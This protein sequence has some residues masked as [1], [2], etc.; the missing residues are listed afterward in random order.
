MGGDQSLDEEEEEEDE[1][2]LIAAKK[3]PASVT[4]KPSVSSG[5]NWGPFIDVYFCGSLFN[6]LSLIEKNEVG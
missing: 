2:T 3:R 5:M 4:Q 6:Q 1:E